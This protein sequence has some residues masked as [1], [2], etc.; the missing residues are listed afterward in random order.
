MSRFPVIIALVLTFPAIA[1]GQD[2]GP[3]D[4]A[5]AFFAAY[6]DRDMNALRALFA[7][8]AQVVRFRIEADGD[9]KIE[10]DD[11]LKWV[12]KE[13]RNLEDV[14]NFAVTLGESKILVTDVA[15]SVSIVIETRRTDRDR[16]TQT[17][18]VATFSL[19]ELGGRWR[20]MQLSSFERE[21]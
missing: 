4:V 7:S 10:K 17:S 8:E 18:G 20:I 11:A 6:A 9:A 14:S 12:S 16:V 1:V 3:E 5:R 19:A 15:A 21:R 13:E 2:E